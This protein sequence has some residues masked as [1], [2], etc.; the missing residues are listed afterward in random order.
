MWVEHGGTRQA[1]Y[2]HC[3]RNTCGCSLFASRELQPTACY[4]H[5]SVSKY[6]LQRFFGVCF[7]WELDFSS[8]C[9][10]HAQLPKGTC[11]LN[12]LRVGTVEPTGQ[13][14]ARTLVE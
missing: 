7:T 3:T 11:A 14:V 12:T 6:S 4:I 2:D 5:P 9:E 13:T 8:L 10:C 1:V